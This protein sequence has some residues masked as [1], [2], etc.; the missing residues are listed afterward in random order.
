MDGVDPKLKELLKL[1]EEEV[2]KLSRFP[3]AEVQQATESA[4]EDWLLLESDLFNG[5]KILFVRD[6]STRVPEE[7]A[8][9]IRY[10][11]A[12]LAEIQDVDESMLRAVHDA[13]K[14]LGGKVVWGKSR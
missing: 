10:T 11:R 5:E 7:L 8:G 9:L 12:E 14:A 2:V 13:K 3:D 1:S 6:E 4:K